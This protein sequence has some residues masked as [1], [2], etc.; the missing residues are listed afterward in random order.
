[1]PGGDYRDGA[2]RARRLAARARARSST[3]TASRSGS[4]AA[5]PAYTVGQRQGLGVA[6]GAPRYV[7]RID[8]LTNTIQLG[9]REDLETHDVRARA[10][11]RSSP[12]APPGRRVPRRRP[13]PPPRRRRSRRDRRATRG[14]RGRW[15]V[16]TDEPVWAAAPGQAAVLYDGDV[17]LG[18]G[19]IADPTRAPRRWRRSRVSVDPALILGVLVGIFNAAAVRAHP[20]LA[21]AAGCRCSS[22]AAILGAWAGDA[23]GARLGLDLLPIGDF[24]LVAASVVAWLGIAF[25]SVVAILGPT[26]AQA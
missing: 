3:P 23:L 21:P 19:R 13:D 10:R 20:R 4:T 5:R 12:A 16:E 15:T 25:V 14:R 2:A 22:V 11:R 9:R 24:R 6:L 1:M 7:S 17:V 26:R 18:G 8:P